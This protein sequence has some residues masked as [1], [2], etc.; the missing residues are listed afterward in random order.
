[1]TN[2]D[3]APRQPVTV[4]KGQAQGRKENVRCEAGS[5]DGGKERAVLVSSSALED[6]EMWIV[7][8][9][10]MLDRIG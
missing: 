1:M 3:A 5:L 4:G 2:R 9:T 10:F 6:R 7:C 8:E